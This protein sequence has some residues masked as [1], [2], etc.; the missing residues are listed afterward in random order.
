MVSVTIRCP[1]CG[2]VWTQQLGVTSQSGVS[3]T[4]RVNCKDISQCRKGFFVTVKNGQ[5]VGYQK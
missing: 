5:I 4:T 3:Q 1:Y 2:K